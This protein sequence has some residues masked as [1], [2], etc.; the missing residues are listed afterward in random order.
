MTTELH[1]IPARRR[2][3]RSYV[4][5][6][7]VLTLVSG[8]YLAQQAASNLD[9]PLAQFVAFV[10]KAG[11]AKASKPAELPDAV[12]AKVQKGAEENAKLRAALAEFQSDVGRLRAGL[13]QRGADTSII[14][15]LSALEERASIE[16]GIPLEKVVAATVPAPA[17]P[18]PAFMPGT[19]LA[20]ASPLPAPVPAAA[21]PAPVPQPIETGSLP[22]LPQRVLSPPPTTVVFS[23]PAAPIPT[24]ELAEKIDSAN[25][26]SNSQPESVAAAPITF[27]PAVVK[28]AAKPF[29]VQLGHGTSLDA[30]R[31]NWSLLAERNGDALGKLQPRYTATPAGDAGE[32]FD[33]VA[34]PVKSA[35]DAK[36]ICKIMAARGID[37]KVG[38]FGGNALL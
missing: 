9:V 37:C 24:P 26:I 6:W 29:A 4:A 14:G 17:D 34:G 25:A 10:S 20:A 7:A 2:L 32:I 27:G 35:A 22:E 16:T 13:E 15:S 38:P 5:T 12:I 3:P 36:K 33:L 30:I 28:P 1:D 31:L 19:G 23:I 21:Q 11:N 18:V 8:T